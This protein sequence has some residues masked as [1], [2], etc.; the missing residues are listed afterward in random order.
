[1]IFTDLPPGFLGNAAAAAVVRPEQLQTFPDPVECPA[2]SKVG[3]VE[4][5]TTTAAVDD[6]GRVQHGARSGLSGPVWPS[7]SVQQDRAAVSAVAS[8]D[9]GYGVSLVSPASRRSASGRLKAT[10]VRGAGRSHQ[11]W[12]QWWSRWPFLSMP[13]DCLDG[14]R[15][16]ASW[17]IRGRI[18]RGRCRPGC[19]D[20][21]L[22]DLSDPLWKSG[23]GGGSAGD[24][25]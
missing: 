11:R 25:V 20:F 5:T 2:D 17:W 18:R 21:G 12:S 8:A 23:V 24:R 16:E 19:A 4:L 1:M 14:R 6:H 3:E 22:P 10:A 15:D 9:G 7:R 13:S